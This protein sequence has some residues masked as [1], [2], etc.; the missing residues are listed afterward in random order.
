MST[1]V[2]VGSTRP[3]VSLSSGRIGCASA[4]TSASAMTA[5]D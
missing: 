4:N 5:T 2:A 1:V 3:G